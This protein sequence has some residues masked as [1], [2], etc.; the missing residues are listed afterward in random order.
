ML[1]TKNLFLF[2]RLGS[3]NQLSNSEIGQDLSYAGTPSHEDGKF[4]YALTGGGTGG[5]SNY[6]YIP[7]NTFTRTTYT[8]EFLVNRTGSADYAQPIAM[9][10]AND[11]LGFWIER[12]STQGARSFAIRLFF[13]QGSATFIEIYKSYGSLAG[14]DAVFPSNTWVHCAVS[15]NNINGEVK[16]YIDNV[17]QGSLTFHAGSASDLTGN[18]GEYAEQCYISTGRS[19]LSTGMDGPTENIKIWEEVKTSFPDRVLPDYSYAKKRR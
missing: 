15:K 4:G 8:Y 10:G 11:Y 14:I 6:V 12:R 7:I 2:N 1:S 13:R 17:D 19:G 3:N 16:I 5:S 9:A 18:T